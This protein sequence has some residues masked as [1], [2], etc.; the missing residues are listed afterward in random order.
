MTASS[1]VMRL[2]KMDHAREVRPARVLDFLGLLTPAPE[3]VG[4]W[5]SKG[6]RASLPFLYLLCFG[7]GFV[8]GIRQVVRFLR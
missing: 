5:R 7:T 6:G 3:E 1:L 2:Q 8:A 4:R